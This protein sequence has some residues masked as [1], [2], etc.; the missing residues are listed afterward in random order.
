M[1]KCV[2]LANASS[3]CLGDVNCLNSMNQKCILS[4]ILSN[5]NDESGCS[6]ESWSSLAGLFSYR[7][8]YVFSAKI[9]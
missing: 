4:D 9:L 6:F 2:L 1:M 5:A 8:T 3:D 7:C